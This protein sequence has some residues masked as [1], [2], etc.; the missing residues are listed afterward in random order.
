MK[1]ELKWSTA[2]SEVSLNRKKSFQILNSYFSKLRTVLTVTIH[3]Q[4]TQQ[5]KHN[6]I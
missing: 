1:A 3:K 6:E 5:T 2:K 4:E